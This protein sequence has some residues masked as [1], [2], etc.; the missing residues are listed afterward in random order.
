[1]H[2]EIV[3]RPDG[4][5]VIRDHQS[6]NG[7]FVNNERLTGDRT[8]GSGD[9]IQL[10]VG[11][12]ELAVL[13]IDVSSPEVPSPVSAPEATE[14]EP[15]RKKKRDRSKAAV[16]AAEKLGSS[17]RSFGGKGA[18]IFF[19]EMFVESS[20]K[21][22]RRL[23]WVVWSFV[24]VIAA[25]VGVAYWYKDRLEGRLQE[26][27][28]AQQAMADSVREA[29]V[30]EYERLQ[31]ELDDA[32]AGSA[33]LVVVESLQV[34]LND[35]QARTDALEEALARAQRSLTAQLAAGDSIRRLAQIELSRLQ[36]ELD[37]AR[38]SGTPEGLLD[39]LRAAVRDAEDRTADIASRIDAVRSGNLASVAQANQ[40][41]V[42][43]VT[44]YIAGGVYDGSGFAITESGYYVTNRHVV[45][46][47]G[48][49]PPD[50]VMV[51]LADQR[52]MR[53]AQVIGAIAAPGPDLALLKITGHDGSHVARI[54]WQGSGARQGEP[55]ALIGFPAGFGN[56]IDASGFVRTTMTAGIFAKITEDL[57]NFDG[58]TVGGSSGSPIFN[59]TG[60]VVAVHRAGLRDAVGMGFAVPIRLLAA[61]LPEEAKAELGLR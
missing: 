15:E 35:A 13:D 4:Q 40:S 23:R 7:T 50:S 33:P 25:G 17:R 55:A 54:D 38:A 45:Q 52:I 21:S 14:K 30:A 28:A 27:L 3:L 1:V 18:T 60:E 51:T 41:A 36:S 2:A 58:F 57:I 6:R 9:R 34:A 49:P 20:K 46:P 59:A 61:L 12:P 10:G 44:A 39:S 8:L 47:S 53:S 24:V 37:R 29:A 19:N 43:L 48:E 42:G 11:G 26:Q 31:R 22:A 56:A 32:R 16:R 5:V